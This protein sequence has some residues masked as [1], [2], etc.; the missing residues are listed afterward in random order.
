M[1]GINLTI[2]DVVLR[3]VKVPLHRPLVTRVVT[4]RDAYLLLIDLRTDEGVTGRA[5]LFGYLPRGPAHLAA[6]LRDV[7][8]L[9]RGERVSPVVIWQRMRKALT[10]YGQEGLTLMAVSGFDMA[11]WD[12]LAR[13]AGVPLVTL[14]GGEP[15]SLPAYNSNGLGLIG[16]REAAK[17]AEALVSEGGFRAVKVRMGRPRL[18]DDLSVLRAVRKA[19]GDDVLLPIDFNQG[20]TVEEAVRR[21]RALD[22]EG[23]YWIEEPV[24]YDDLAGSARV[25]AEV[26]T[27]VQIGE[28]FFG[29]RALA[30]AVAAQACDWVMPDAQRIG[31]VT[32]WLRAAALAETAGIEMSSHILPEISCHLLAVTPTRH[33]L[34]Y[35]DWASPV[36]AEPVR[37]ADGHIVVPDRPGSGMDWDEPAVRR[38][39][40]EP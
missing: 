17:E 28:N 38:F 19:V 2:R 3:P 12:A 7:L 36:L 18:E 31:G 4:I 34:E 5:Y 40:Y 20:L 10:L 15:G 32:G 27:P 29:P 13:A 35:V 11:A 16:A 8:D 6:L 37:P 26:A 1:S 24:A 9:V 21:G 25:T 33:W 22:S 23:V 39:A 30:D 14:L